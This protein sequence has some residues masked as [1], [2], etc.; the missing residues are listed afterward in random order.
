MANEVRKKLR[1]KILA[2]AAASTSATGF[3]DGAETPIANTYAASENGLGADTAR[4]SIAVTAAPATAAVAE[5]WTSKYD[6]E[7]SRYE[8]YEYALSVDIPTTSLNKTYS[9]GWIEL[10][11]TLTKA[12]INAV[13][14]AFKA[15]LIATPILPEIQ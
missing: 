2:Q 6:T 12:K 1:T 7:N 5:V 13:N 11:S 14:Y 4:M 9:A 3:S 8:E 15:Q 10:D